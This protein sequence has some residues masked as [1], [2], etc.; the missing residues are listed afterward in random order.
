M[1]ATGL[2]F[3]PIFAILFVCLAVSLTIIASIVLIVRGVHRHR[4]DR[5]L[6]Q[7]EEIQFRQMMAVLDK[8]EQ[9]IANLE[10]ILMRQD[11]SRDEK[12]AS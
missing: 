6:N 1:Q 4:D 7:D 3:V 11:P 5:R 8:M 9:R 12:T 2:A 10:T